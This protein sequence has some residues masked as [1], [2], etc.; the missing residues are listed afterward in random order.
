[1]S[2]EKQFPH[3]KEPEVIIRGW[4]KDAFKENHRL[5]DNTVIFENSVETVDSWVNVKPEISLQIDGR[6]LEKANHDFA[7]GDFIEVQGELRTKNVYDNEGNKIQRR[8][9]VFVKSIEI[10]DEAS[11]PPMNY[12]CVSGVMA[13]KGKIH[14]CKNGDSMFDFTLDIRRSY[15][16]RSSIPCVIWGKERSQRLANL[17]KDAKVEVNGWLKSRVITD[18][19]GITKSVIE[20]IVDNIYDVK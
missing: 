19:A 16:R 1:M 7:K 13:R 9:Y 5:D 8:C 15:G 4:L 10:L 12:V 11:A 14:H 20:V 17:S 2:I 18:S 3:K 6:R